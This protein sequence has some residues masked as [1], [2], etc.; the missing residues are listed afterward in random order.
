MNNKGERERAR[1]NNYKKTKGQLKVENV[2]WEVRGLCN[3]KIKKYL[4]IFSC[5]F[6]LTPLPQLDLEAVLSKE[7]QEAQSISGFILGVLN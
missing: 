3:P 6:A 4:L 7:I 2:D 1:G 5:S